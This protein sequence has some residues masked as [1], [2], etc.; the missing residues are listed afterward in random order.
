MKLSQTTRYAINWLYSQ[1][2]NLDDI[3]SKLNIKRPTVVEYIEKN[4]IQ[5]DAN[6]SITSEP[7]SNSKNLMV[8]HTSEKKINNVAIMTKAAS[9]FNDAQRLKSDNKPRDCSSYIFRPN[10]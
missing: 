2:Y 7:V 5:N 1:G 3:A 10:E 9:E 8:R 4:N 6:L